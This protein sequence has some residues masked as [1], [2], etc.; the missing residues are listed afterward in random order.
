MLNL[1]WIFFLQ[2]LIWKSF[3]NPSQLCAYMN[4]VERFVLLKPV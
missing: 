4:K 3:F 2:I 1:S